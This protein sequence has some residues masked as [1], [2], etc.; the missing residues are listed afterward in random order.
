MDY[1]DVI[2]WMRLCPRVFGP[3]VSEQA[4]CGMSGWFVGG[5]DD[6]GAVIVCEYSGVASLGVHGVH[7]GFG[8][9]A[10]ESVFEFA[11]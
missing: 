1:R 5:A 3:Q 4:G 8:A 7:S 2:G 6:L 11:R 10:V 9:A